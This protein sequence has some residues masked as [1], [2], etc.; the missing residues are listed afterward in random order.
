MGYDV[1][2]ISPKINKVYPKRYNE[3]MKEYGDGEGWLKWGEDI[4]EEIKDEYFELK[5]Q[6]QTDNPGEYFRNNV[7]FWRP[8]WK[9]VCEVCDDFMTH[10]EIR[11][12]STKKLKNILKN[13][14]PDVDLHDMIDYE[15]YIREY[16]Q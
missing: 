12:A 11:R 10:D 13:D 6:Y 14:D 1:Y 5:D 4:P 2:G 15:L 16:S 7:W 8:L 9:Y 3:I